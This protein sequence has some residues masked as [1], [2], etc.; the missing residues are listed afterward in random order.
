[1]L[2]LNIGEGNTTIYRDAFLFHPLCPPFGTTLHAHTYIPVLDL[3]LVNY[4]VCTYVHTYVV[5]YI[6]SSYIIC[7]MYVC[8]YVHVTYNVHTYLRTYVCTYIYI[9]TYN[10]IFGK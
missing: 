5:V 2:V 1:M 4:Y 7:N 10:V 8:T 6:V 3:L 9:C